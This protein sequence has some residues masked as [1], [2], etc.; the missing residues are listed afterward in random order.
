MDSHS[1]KEV[2]TQPVPA[3]FGDVALDF[4]RSKLGTEKVSWLQER[5]CHHHGT[6][7]S[8]SW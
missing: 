2:F 3:L 6:T 8:G 1:P 4:L 7:Q 5:A